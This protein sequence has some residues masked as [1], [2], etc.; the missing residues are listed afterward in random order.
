MFLLADCFFIHFL[1]KI[2]SWFWTNWESTKLIRSCAER[3]V[4]IKL[5]LSISSLTIIFFL[6]E[7][8]GWYFKFSLKIFIFLKENFVLKLQNSKQLFD[9]LDQSLKDVYDKYKDSDGFIYVSYCE[10]SSFGQWREKT[11]PLQKG[12]GSFYSLLQ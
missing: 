9:L 8:R 1:W 4:S 11:S 3:W 12:N 6:E 10:Y 2:D 7:V 5:M